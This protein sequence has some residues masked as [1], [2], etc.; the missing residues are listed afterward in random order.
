MLSFLKTSDKLNIGDFMESLQEIVK[1]L[2]MLLEEKNLPRNVRSGITTAKA[3]LEDMSKAENIRAS[4][5][6]YELDKVVNDI[7]ISQHF[8]LRLMNVIAK[9]EA[10]TK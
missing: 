9:L 2:D 4:L 5:A 8:R 10:K 1:S 7:N 6:I 3:I